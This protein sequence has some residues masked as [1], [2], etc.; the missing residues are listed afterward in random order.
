MLQFSFFLFS[1]LFIPYEE[2]CWVYGIEKSNFLNKRSKEEGGRKKKRRK[3]ILFFEH[4]D[5]F[6]LVC[7]GSFSSNGKCFYVW[8]IAW[9]SI[10][11]R[12]QL[13]LS[14]SHFSLSPFFFLPFTFF[15][16]CKSKKQFFFNHRFP[17]IDVLSFLCFQLEWKEKVL[18]FSFFL[19]IHS[20]LFFYF[21]CC[22]FSAFSI[23]T[24]KIAFYTWGKFLQIRVRMVTP[25]THQTIRKKL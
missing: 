25:E 1:L 19:L 9:H 10:A 21:V 17:V 6:S 3:R 22:S 20:V 23:A 16:I 14:I 2:N 11:L 13:A 5:W 4:R 7:C 8:K 18:I 12:P 15:F 24:I